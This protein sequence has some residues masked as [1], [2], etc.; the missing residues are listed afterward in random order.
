M[1]PLAYFSKSVPVR[2][3]H[4][5]SAF[6]SFKQI[7]APFMSSPQSH[8]KSMCIGSR[9][10][11]RSQLA[12]TGKRDSEVSLTNNYY[13][14]REF[15]SKTSVSPLN[16]ESKHLKKLI[17]LTQNKHQGWHWG[18]N[19][20]FWLK[21]PA[22]ADRTF[23]RCQVFSN[24]HWRIFSKACQWGLFDLQISVRSASEIWVSRIKN[25]LKY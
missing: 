10:S 23:G 3:G 4:E 11:W 16:K 12:D 6:C 24:P 5:R 22:N 1:S 8:L 7:A 18:R 17:V 25:A 13:F 21:T 2:E 9:L 14:S 15:V 20:I 19:Q